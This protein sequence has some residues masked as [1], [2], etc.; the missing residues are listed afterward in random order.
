MESHHPFPVSQLVSSGCEFRRSEQTSFKLPRLNASDNLAAVSSSRS[1]TQGINAAGQINRAL[2][3]SSDVLVTSKIPPGLG[4]PPTSAGVNGNSRRPR[5]RNASSSKLVHKYY[6]FDDFIR[7]GWYPNAS[8]TS[9]N[10]PWSCCGIIILKLS[11]NIYCAF[12]I[13]TNI[14]AICCRCNY[15]QSDKLPEE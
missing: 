1:P 14:R 11:S 7:L 12:G 15:N 13:E 2:Y 3:L 9:C 10:N 4:L 8:T 5:G 6:P